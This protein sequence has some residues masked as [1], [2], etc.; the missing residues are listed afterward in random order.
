MV[1][2]L[3][4]LQPMVS[5]IASTTSS[6]TNLTVSSISYYFWVILLAHLCSHPTSLP[7][8]NCKYCSISQGFFE[9][10]TLENEQ[11]LRWMNGSAFSVCCSNELKNSSGSENKNKVITTAYI[12]LDLRSLICGFGGKVYNCGWHHFTVIQCALLTS[13]SISNCLIAN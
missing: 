4:V 6:P 5:Y 11:N 3:I 2:H 10:Q 12:V 7:E 13:L 8:Y 9:Q 1:S